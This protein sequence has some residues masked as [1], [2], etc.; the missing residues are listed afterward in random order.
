MINQIN[1]IFQLRGT[2][3]EKEES[4]LTQRVVPRM[5]RDA[6][7][8]NIKSGRWVN[9]QIYISVVLKTHISHCQSLSGYF[10]YISKLACSNQVPKPKQV[11]PTLILSH[12]AAIFLIS[13]NFLSYILKFLWKYFLNSY[14]IFYLMEAAELLSLFRNCWTFRLILNFMV[15][16]WTFFLKLFFLLFP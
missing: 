12:T 1:F 10:L 7:N 15:L 11:F 14:I 2:I 6:T 5:S 8:R 9:S 4:I 13:M 3:K 16:Q